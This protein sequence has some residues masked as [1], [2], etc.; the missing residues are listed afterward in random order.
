MERSRT[1]VFIAAVIFIMSVLMPAAALASGEVDAGIRL[2]TDTVYGSRA[3]DG[4]ITANALAK[5]PPV[6]FA[7]EDGPAKWYRCADSSFAASGPCI[8]RDSTLALNADMLASGTGDTAYF[9]CFAGSDTCRFAITTVSEPM[10]EAVVSS[11]TDVTS[12]PYGEDITGCRVQA[13]WNPPIPPEGITGYVWS[14]DSAPGT[15]K[16]DN[17]TLAQGGSAVQTPD[18][19]LGISHF[20][21]PGDYDLKCAPIGYNK[22]AIGITIR[23]AAPAGFARSVSMRADDESN[24]GS[25]TGDNTGSGSGEDNT[26]SGNGTEAGGSDGDDESQDSSGSEGSEGDSSGDG[27]STGSEDPEPTAEPTPEPDAAPTLTGAV[28]MSGEEPYATASEG[29]L[30]SAEVVASDP[31]SLSVTAEG[32]TGCEENPY[33]YRWYV[34]EDEESELPE[35]ASPVAT[36]AVLQPRQVKPA[37][38]ADGTVYYRCYVNVE[39]REAVA[40]QNFKLTTVESAQFVVDSAKTSPETVLNELPVGT[41]LSD[42]TLGVRWDPP[43]VPAGFD[44]YTWSIESGPTGGSIATS[45]GTLRGR[46]SLT[47]QDL[48][49]E[50]QRIS[51]AGTYKLK[52]VPASSTGASSDLSVSFTLIAGAPKFQDKVAFYG[53]QGTDGHVSTW[54]TAKAS[55]GKLAL[56]VNTRFSLYIPGST[57]GMTAETADS[58]DIEWQFRIGDSGSVQQIPSGYGF[59]GVDSTTLVSGPVSEDMNRWQFRMMV[60][61]TTD[62]TLVDYS[63]WVALTVNPVPS[64]TPRVAIYSSPTARNSEIKIGSGGTVTL[65]ADVTNKSQFHLANICYQWYVE[66]SGVG[67]T[68]IEGATDSTYTIK[69]I[70]PVLDGARYWC[71]AYNRGYLNE[72]GVSSKVILSVETE[73]G[74]VVFSKPAGPSIQLL[75]TGSGAV[76]S[77]SARALGDSDV[78][79]QWQRRSKTGNVTGITTTVAA[80][81]YLGTAAYSDLQNAE[82]STLVTGSLAPGVYEYSCKAY[83]EGNESRSV[84]SAGFYLV[85]ATSVTTPVIVSPATNTVV[86]E[87]GVFGQSK[88]L[89][90]RAYLP[91]NSDPSYQW[92]TARATAG[93]WSDLDGFTASEMRIPSLSEQNNGQFYRCLVTNPKT[94]TSRASGA[95]RVSVW[96]ASDMPVIV[97]NPK[98]IEY[99]ILG[100]PTDTGISSD[101]TVYMESAAW[102]ESGA[103]LYSQWQYQEMGSSVWQNVPGASQ[104]RM[105][106][107]TG[108]SGGTASGG[109]SRLVLQANADNWAP[110]GFYRCVWTTG[111][112]QKPDSMLVPTT[113]SQAARLDLLYSG[114][115]RIIDQSMGAEVPIGGTA[116]FYV[117]IQIDDN[118]IPVYVWQMTRDGGKTWN[119]CITGVDGTGQYTNVFTTYGATREMF[120]ENE[121]EGRATDD[122]SLFLYRCIVANRDLSFS[123]VSVPAPLVIH[124]VSSS[125]PSIVPGSGSQVVIARVDGTKYAKGPSVSGSGTTAMEYLNELGYEAPAGYTLELQT[126]TGARVQ[127][128]AIVTSGMRL[129]LT[130]QKTS[131]VVDT[132]D[133]VIMGDIIGTGTADLSQVVAIAAAYRG[134]RKLSGPFFQAAL[135]VGGTTINLSDVVAEARLF[136]QS[137]T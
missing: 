47:T 45:A 20:S 124:D 123:T 90:C 93:P 18:G 39:G 69:D 77:A 68:A 6:L 13:S 66:R 12:I 43:A 23:T 95:Y 127:D 135:L 48:V 96:N 60:M 7:T 52:C 88:Y 58:Y 15:V 35:E 137:Y 1:A 114:H 72:T 65:E 97:E 122:G 21:A 126:A 105:D 109:R 121:D 71:E 118:S 64:I 86:Y 54:P 44:A 24:G 32:G 84:A 92:Q 30:C 28:A 79:Y 22:S 111:S 10:L 19:S 120:E 108:I 128:G 116:T 134:T 36:A 94:N 11:D 132:A 81:A 50:L 37:E 129:L 31:P 55:S 133:V 2:G 63:D 46:A 104:T 56:P 34:C 91:D 59:F 136:R 75:E 49:V 40:A 17:G 38:E 119:N 41:V 98:S 29:E 62:T 33:Q 8:S 115:P 130:Q 16:T 67:T 70:G 131:E 112:L 110:N 117:D 99:S 101:N 83:T 51:V 125:T 14:L 100:G 9:K 85:V 113:S 42:I 26:G 27:D 73:D 76:L 107:P 61:C 102:V 82:D 80:Q 78:L 4:T 5:Q 89:G 87:G 3:A 74:T 25:G 53:V 103:N 57:F 106:A